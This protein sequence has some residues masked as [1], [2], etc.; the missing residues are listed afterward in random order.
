MQNL[1]HFVE[2]CVITVVCSFLFFYGLSKTG[3]SQN[4][5]TLG[6]TPTTSAG[7]HRRHHG[8]G[9]K[10]PHHPYYPPPQ[11]DPK[12]PMA[13]DYHHRSHP[14]STYSKGNNSNSNSSN[15]KKKNNEDYYYTYEEDYE[16]KQGTT[17]ST[18][19]GFLRDNLGWVVRTT[20][21]ESQSDELLVVDHDY[22]FLRG[23]T[24]EDK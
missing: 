12:E 17:R 10:I 15:K 8:H 18:V 6:A 13:K 11:K 14:D 24:S 5:V 4:L 9:H 3:R 16:T 7:F 21:T 1:R 20:E 22:F 19:A 2:L 23:T